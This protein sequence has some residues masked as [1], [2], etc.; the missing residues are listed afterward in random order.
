MTNF[1]TRAY[2]IAAPVS[3][4]LLAGLACSMGAGTPVSQINGPSVTVTSPV[5]GQVLP[6]GQPIPV[7]S[8]S[9][10]PHGI[11][12]VELWVDNTLLRVDNNPSQESPYIVTQTWQSET[13]GTHV[14]VVKAIDVNGIA[15]EAQPTAITL[16][17]QS[18]VTPGW[19]EVATESPGASAEPSPTALVA[20]QTPSHSPTSTPSPS[21]SQLPTATASNTPVVMCTPPA[22]GEGEVY[23]CQGD[24]PGGCGTQC[25]TPTPTLTPPSFEA[26]G[27]EV[28]QIFQADWENPEVGDYLGYPTQPASDDRRYARQY[29]EHGYLY[30]WDQPDGQG[31]IWAVE[32][33]QPGVNRGARWSGPYEDTWDGGDR[34]SCQA[35]R[36]TSA[37]PVAG[38]GKL[39][40]ERPEIAKA[41]G[42][43]IEAEQGTGESTSYGV[44]Q[45]FQN[46][47]M[48]YSPLDHEVFVLF[49][50]GGW[51]RY[52]R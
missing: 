6:V 51:R 45:F 19:T 13:P 10:S 35:A 48:L 42:I 17:V 36:A 15:G 49:N 32:M 41:I 25:A 22:C 29:F 43:P 23:Y 26:T 5:A 27:I 28:Q 16:E 46:G 44:V 18:E 4:L 20:T 14:I 39:W 8:T 50:S 31:L 34:F 40:C 33:P 38:F 2:R 7:S 30:W 1:F 52:S 24:C 11:Q 9:D 37:G 12:R 47:V 3:I 21:R